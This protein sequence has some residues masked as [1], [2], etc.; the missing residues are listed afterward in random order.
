MTPSTL[1]IELLTNAKLIPVIE[2]ARRAYRSSDRYSASK[3]AE[4]VTEV[5]GRFPGH[6]V[7]HAATRIDSVG[8]ELPLTLLSLLAREH[9]CWVRG[10]L[11]LRHEAYLRWRAT[12]SARI[13]VDLLWTTA[14]AVECLDDEWSPFTTLG[15]SAACCS[16]RKRDALTL[17]EHNRE[18][19][20][21]GP[22][23]PSLS[24]LMLD[25][26]RQQGLPELHR[27]QNLARLPEMMWCDLL[28]DRD[29]QTETLKG[30]DEEDK[31]LLM[32]ARGLHRQLRQALKADEG[33]HAPP[34]GAEDDR[35]GDE[36]TAPSRATP[37]DAED[38]L[39]LRDCRRDAF[40]ETA[41]LVYNSSYE[42]GH[43]P[44]LLWQE[45]D[46]LTRAIQALTAER[47]PAPGFVESFHIYLLC[48]AQ[49]HQR[50]VQPPE[51]VK[52]LD[53]FKDKYVDGLHKLNTEDRSRAL[54]QAW[55][56]G[57]VR[58]IE[59]RFSPYSPHNT[60]HELRATIAKLQASVALLESTD[61]VSLATL[62]EPDSTHQ[63]P[64]VRIILHFIRNPDEFAP[65]AGSAHVTKGWSRHHAQ[66]TVIRTQAEEVW[67]MLGEL[68]ARRAHRRPSTW[69]AMS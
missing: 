58:W 16:L 59:L 29:Q 30:L 9:L 39:T 17:D 42:G 5:L 3:L 65:G 66:R 21:H 44:S 49:L 47:L 6:Q 34:H 12:R 46:L 15:G 33:R 48:R 18:A 31:R 28:F 10:E 4:C 38:W 67:E 13:S 36:A 41:P 45:R 64:G 40:H 43:H 24:L 61:E 52:G 35:A 11:R 25:S 8:G 50:L 68:G 22:I 23:I 56:T 19:Q 20:L 63:R 1:V 62:R 53:R 14:L 27:H 57:A 2:E 7:T 32:L 37:R 69:R 26:L 55:R 54:V 51:G 60:A